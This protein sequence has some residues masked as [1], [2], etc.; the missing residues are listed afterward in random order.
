MIRM[1]VRDTELAGYLV[2]HGA[3][4][5][6]DEYAMHHRPDYFSDPQTFDPS[7][8][9]PEN[10]NLLPKFAY[11]PFGTGPRVCIGQH[12]ALMEAQLVLASLNQR[13]QFEL[14]Q[15]RSVKPKAELTLHTDGSIPAIVHH[16]SKTT[17]D[18]LNV[19]GSKED[20][21]LITT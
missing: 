17:A 14:E 7:R 20:R 10:E 21:R 2:P 12:F 8:F 15:D 6:I 5:L 16:R 19:I 18:T 4:V 1:S 13:V 9:T 11:L 3:Y